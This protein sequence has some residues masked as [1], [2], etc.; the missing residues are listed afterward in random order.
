MNFNY[1]SIDG[2]EIPVTIY[3]TQSLSSFESRTKSTLAELENDYGAFPHQKVVI[4]GAGSGGMEYCGATMTSLWALSHELTHS[5]FARGVMPAAGNA[6]WIDEAIASWRDADYRQSSLSSLSPSQMAGHS[7]YTR[8]TD[9]DAYSKG[10]R[11]MGYLDRLFTAQG[12][13]KKFLR[14]LVEKRLFKPMLNEEFKQDLE[15]YFNHSL[16]NEFSK[17]IMGKKGD[18]FDYEVANPYHPKLT[19]SQLLKLL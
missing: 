5:Y 10:E 8:M 17:Y 14:D 11:F 6:G 9:D 2:R 1:R 7:V 18:K 15:L 16:D 3:S 19:P 13:L 12:G 4:Y